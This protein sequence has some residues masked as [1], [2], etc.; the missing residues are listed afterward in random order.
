MAMLIDGKATSRAVRDEIRAETERFLK[1][2]GMLP[3]LAVVIVGEDP[4]FYTLL[5]ELFK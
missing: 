1:A 4:A 5:D 2:T 3:G